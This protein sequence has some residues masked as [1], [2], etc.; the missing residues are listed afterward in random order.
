MVVLNVIVM[1]DTLV[2][3]LNV[4]NLT[5]SQYLMTSWEV[6]PVPRDIPEVNSIVK[7]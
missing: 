7:I 4:K 1:T 6:G 5:N 3:D 2:M